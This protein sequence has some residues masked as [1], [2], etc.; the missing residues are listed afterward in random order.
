MPILKYIFDN[1]MYKYL[2]N[3]YINL[4]INESRPKIIGAMYVTK[5]IL[6]LIIKIIILYLCKYMVC[7]HVNI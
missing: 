2:C 6:Q 5:I 3:L 4:C 1:I 7:N